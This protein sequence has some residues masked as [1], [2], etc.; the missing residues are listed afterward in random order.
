MRRQQSTVD[1]RNS[2][3]D[4]ADQIGFLTIPRRSGTRRTT[5]VQL[6]VRVR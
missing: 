6:A 2:L 3:L 1:M 5:M 4:G